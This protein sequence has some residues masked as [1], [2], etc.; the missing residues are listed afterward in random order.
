MVAGTTRVLRGSILLDFAIIDSFFPLV[1]DGKHVYLHQFCNSPL[2][3]RFG[4]ES[5]RRR[6]A[7]REM[8]V[9]VVL[10]EEEEE[11]EDNKNEK[12]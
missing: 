4:D 10:E 1:F 9:V 6:K 12:R 11:E 2:H 7:G 3:T 8:V 5:G